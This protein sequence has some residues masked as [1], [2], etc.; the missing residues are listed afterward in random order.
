MMN[1]TLHIIIFLLLSASLATAQLVPLLSQYS[2][3]G[4]PS[5]PGYAGSNEVLSVSTSYR[6]QWV[7]F[8]GAPTTQ[9][10]GLHTPLKNEKVALGF[11]IYRDVIGKHYDNGF[12]ATYAYRVKFPSGKLSMG[13]SAGLSAKRSLLSEAHINDSGD[14]VFLENTPVNFLPDFS[15]GTYYYSTEYYVGFSIPFLLTHQL[16]VSKGKFRTKHYFS[17]YNFLLNAGYTY[18][19]NNEL[20]LLPSIISRMHV[21]T[22][23]QFEP[24]I[25]GEYKKMVGFGIAYRTGDAI[26][27]IGKYKLNNQLSLGY[28]FDVTTSE[29]RNYNSGTHELVLSYIFKYESLS[30]NPRFFQ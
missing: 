2:L 13:L 1:K 10:V 4:F 26:I 30:Q 29:L 19:I 8:D 14:P 7:G 15:F 3:N 24:G 6:N 16:D 9:T 28:S 18:Q 5:N 21:K 11:L 27:L 17:E 12:Y 20:I 23:M 22:G 25:A